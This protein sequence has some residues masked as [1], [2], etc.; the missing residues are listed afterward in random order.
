MMP[1]FG[2]GYAMEARH[3][4]RRNEKIDGG[5]YRA[6]HFV[7]GGELRGRKLDGMVSECLHVKPTFWVRLQI[8]LLRYL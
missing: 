7:F 8:Q 4:P 3:T 6:I 1:G 2:A 5:R